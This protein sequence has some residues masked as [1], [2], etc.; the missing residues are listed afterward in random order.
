MERREMSEELQRLHEALARSPELGDHDRELLERLAAD[1]NA[2]LARPGGATGA[3]APLAARLADAVTRFETTH[4][5]LAG[6]LAGVSKVLG[7]MGI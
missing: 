2:L 1:I 4:P 7:D 6:V 3:H 5:D